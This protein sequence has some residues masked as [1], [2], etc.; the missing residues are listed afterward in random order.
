MQFL[1]LFIVIIGAAAGFLAT[2]I[3]KYEAGILLTVGL[4]IIG[5]FLGAITMRAAF[6]FV[7]PF[8][9]FA[10]AVAGAM[11]VTW[12]YRRYLAPEPPEA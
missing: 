10:G 8:A 1:I 9:G 7:G 5:A 6:F 12:L 3:M 11:I 2:R 4:G